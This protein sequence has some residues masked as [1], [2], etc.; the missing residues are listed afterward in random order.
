MSPTALPDVASLREQFAITQARFSDLS[1][2][3]A[4]EAEAMR[5]GGEPPS[6]TLLAELQDA[7][8]VFRRV[9]DDVLNAAAALDVVLA[10]AGEEIGSLRELAPVLDALASAAGIAEQRRAREATRQAALDVLERVPAIAHRDE[11]AFPPLAQCQAHAAAVRDAIAAARAEDDTDPPVWLP[12][13]QP[14]TDLLEMVEGA[15]VID[16]QRWSELA[17]RVGAAFGRPLAVAATRGR[18]RRR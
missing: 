11:A 6:A 18:L 4:G 9:R 14:F 17:E 16:D 1:T 8:E 15:S 3:L 5:D 13:V 7:A 10:V 2:R 12:L